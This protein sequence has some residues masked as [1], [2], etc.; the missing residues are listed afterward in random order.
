MA[1]GIAKSLAARVYGVTVLVLVVSLGTYAF[2]LARSEAG[3]HQAVVIDG[4]RAMLSV[5]SESL[6]SEMLVGDFAGVDQS[7]LQIAELPGLLRL[8]A[9]EP[10][11]TVL[12]DVR[13]EGARRHLAA[14]PEPRRLVTPRA[15]EHERTEI[16]AGGDTLVVWHAVTAGDQL[17]GWVRATIDLGPLH[18]TLRELGLRAVLLAAGSALASLALLFWILRRPLGAIRRLA[19]FARLLPER[20]GEWVSVP[21]GTEEIDQLRDSLNFASAELLRGEQRLLANAA[22]KRSLE[23]QLLQAQKMEALGVLAGG[24]AHDFN[25]LLTAISG[26]A[27]LAAESA[28]SKALGE[29]LE[30]ILVATERATVLT[31]SLLAFGRKQKAEIA[32]VDLNTLVTGIAKILR[33]VVGEDVEVRVTTARDPVVVLADR[34]QLDQVLMNL[35]ANARDAMPHGGVLSLSTSLVTAPAAAGWPGGEAPSAAGCITVTDTGLGMDEAVRRRI[36]EPFFTTKGTGRGTGLGLSIVHGIVAQHRGT[37]E[38]ES[39]VGGGTTFRTLLPAAG[40]LAG[41]ASSRP[42]EGAETPGQ[43]T[44]LLVEDDPQVSRV[45]ALTLER[46]GY[47][48]VSAENGRR[49]LDALRDGKEPIDLLLSDVIMPEMNGVELLEEAR[50]R[51]PG[52]PVILMSGYTADALRRR[53]PLPRDV[54][55]LSKPV[56]P[57]AVRAKVRELLATRAT[58]PPA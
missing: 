51:L 21:S 37:I 22:E 33:R 16:D 9:C 3:Q 57:H 46:A 17:L 50:R 32:P 47:T 5:A 10:D 26:Y 49:G 20:K 42:E 7:L 1:G 18:A 8:Q 11:G 25:N 31:R 24:V 45:L 36:F 34:N 23:A 54:E 30:Q 44:V 27:N 48:V 52:L 14:L 41:E 40:A 28:E 29:D 56:T 39:R 35:A 4:A 55:V 19:D 53:G 2:L 38:V 15:E 12:S 58:A 6:A 13:R 43:G